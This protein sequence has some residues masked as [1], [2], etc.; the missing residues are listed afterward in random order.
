MRLD[1]IE[2]WIVLIIRWELDHNLD[3]HLVLMAFWKEG[4]R[5]IPKKV[6]QRLYLDIF[7]FEILRL[8]DQFVLLE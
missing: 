6:Y 4:R 8:Y 7:P 2:M 1:G 5:Q 3:L